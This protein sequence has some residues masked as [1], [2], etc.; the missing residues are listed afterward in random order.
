[1]SVPRVGLPFYKFLFL[2]A[3][4][5]FSTSAAGA[6]IDG[7]GAMG[8]SGTAG[9]TV[10]KSW[11]PVLVNQRG[12]NFG[13]GANSYNVAQGGATSNSLLASGQHT[14][15]AGLVSSGNVTLPTLLIGT[16]DF[17]TATGLQLANGTLSAAQVQSFINTR[18]TN[19][20]TAADTVLAAGPQGFIL[21]GLPDV[22]LMP[23]ANPLNA[24]QATR[25]RDA[26]TAVNSQLLSYATT[27]N[28]TYVQT[29]LAMQSLLS[30]GPVTIGGVPIDVDGSGTGAFFFRDGIHPGA[31]GNGLIANIF[32]EALN[33]GYGQSI[34]PLNDFEILA[35]AG[36]EG[37]YSGETFSNQAD[38]SPFIVAA[39]VPEPGAATATWLMLIVVGSLR[40]GARSRRS[41][42]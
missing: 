26:V 20:T 17:G 23:Q 36:L 35:L 14:T 33:T 32:I 18:V 34:T 22:T 27:R 4:S 15:M 11:V 28:I 41:P 6:V 31:I 30:A 19:I 8:D 40:R 25:V 9:G 2:L 1:M 39:I 10:N 29:D 7:L 3:V 37:S 13:P 21:F 5:L 16:N 12:I 38:F 24:S 42:C